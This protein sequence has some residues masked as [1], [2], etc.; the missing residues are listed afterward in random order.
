[1]WGEWVSPET[2]DSR[3]WPRT[4]A[5]AER[6]WSPR[7]VRDVDDMYRRLAVIS[8]QLEQL[9][10]THKKNQDMMLRRL[11]R[12]ADIA[13]L[14]TLVSIIEPVKEYRR[15]QVRPQTMLS[16]LTGVVD[17]TTP[18]SEAA[19]RL[20]QM[21]DAFLADAPRFL[22]YREEITKTLDD[23]E[24]SAVSLNALIDQSPALKEIKPLATNLLDLGATGLES[25]AHLKL[26]S[27]AT[28]EWR[29]MRFATLDEA[30]KPY[31]ALEF[32]V[33]PSLRK[34][35]IAAA[36]VHRLETMNAA[37]WNKHVSRLASP[38]KK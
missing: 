33:I 24:A 15:Y 5:I 18:D 12:S 10:L 7:N 26:N 2:I 29:E 13:P 6:L 34:L 28:A 21:V 38:T 37:D 25:V 36:E 35:V 23:W 3:I 16:P 22:V 4:A 11:V 19:R 30:A 17:A 1:M 20:A 14:R 9:G 8:L 32:V 31:G 27:P